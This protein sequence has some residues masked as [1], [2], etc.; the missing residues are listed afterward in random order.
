MFRLTGQVSSLQGPKHNGSH[1]V[2]IQSTTATPHPFLPW[3]SVWVG[4]VKERR[5]REKESGDMSHPIRCF[6]PEKGDKIPEF[7]N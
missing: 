5:R 1:V 3:R 2:V 6:T 7:N 4:E